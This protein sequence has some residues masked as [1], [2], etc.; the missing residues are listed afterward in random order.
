[1]KVIIKN[2][3]KLIRI[4]L[5]TLRKDSLK[6]L[7]SF[8]LDGAELG[9]LFVGDRRM[10]YLNRVYRNVDRT[11]DVLSFPLYNSRE[12]MPCGVEFLL[13]DVVINPHQAR[14]Q[15]DACGAGFNEEMR[16]L[17]I[18]GFLHLLGY[19]HERTPYEARKMKKAEKALRRTLETL[20]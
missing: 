14:K 15:A 20:A 8:S 7:T 1:M 2:Q 9:I 18:H 5:R 3:Q 4:N 12:E 6:L 13:G 11:T 17:L 16:R 19:D 10:K